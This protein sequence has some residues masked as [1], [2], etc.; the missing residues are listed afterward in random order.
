MRRLAYLLC[1]VTFIAGPAVGGPNEA[2]F[3]APADAPPDEF[4]NPSPPLQPS[5]ETQREIA[6]RCFLTA[7][8]LA[9]AGRYATA[10]LLF[11]EAYAAQPHYLVLYNI[12]Q[13][14]LRLGENASAALHLRQFLDEAGSAIDDAWRQ[15]IEAEIQGLEAVNPGAKDAEASSG[16][17]SSPAA[18]MSPDLS[19]LGTEDRGPEAESTNPAV[20]AYP[21]LVAGFVLVGGA[22]G[23]YVW[24]HERHRDWQRQTSDL[25]AFKDNLINRGVPPTTEPVLRQRAAESDALLRSIQRF[26]VVPFAIG[27]VGAAAMGL[28]VWAVVQSRDRPTWSASFG[29]SDLELRTTVVW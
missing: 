17:S 1:A 21:A 26:D 20:W 8:A 15:A 29:P 18:E 3:G 16:A 22:V 5:A 4:R 27:A 23:A 12:A 19:T 6:H 25:Q 10:K 24:N 9:R 11:M 7:V 13:A 14:E 2:K 28:G